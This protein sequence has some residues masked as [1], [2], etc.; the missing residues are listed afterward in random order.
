MQDAL[1]LSIEMLSK[2]WKPDTFMYN[3]KK[4]YLHTITTPNRFV[5]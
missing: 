4:S 3:G 5:R 1:A 2:I